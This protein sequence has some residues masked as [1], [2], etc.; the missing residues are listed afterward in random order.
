VNA[1]AVRRYQ[2]AFTLIELLV[3]IAIIAILAA[4]LFP[5]FAQ[6]REKSRS[7]ACQSNLKQLGTGLLMY[8]DDWDDTYP[9]GWYQ[10]DEAKGDYGHWQIKLSRYIG[11]S[12]D[13]GQLT[14][15]RT[16]PSALAGWNWTYSYNTNL[17]YLSMSELIHPSITLA[18]GDGT[19]VGAWNWGASAT[20][21]G[22]APQ[23]DEARGIHDRDPEPSEGDNVYARKVRYRHS[24]GANFCFADGHVKWYKRGTLTDDNWIAAKGQGRP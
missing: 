20:F 13:W 14:S 22:I 4:I 16:C 2:K 6:A 21:N 24:G 10:G 12:R 15:I 19:Q 5:V 8:L 18:F 17:N 11:E 7:S 1:T 9:P 23:K 3:V